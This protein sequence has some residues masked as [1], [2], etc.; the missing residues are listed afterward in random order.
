M[1]A[2]PYLRSLLEYNTWANA[3]LYAKVRELP[4]E[5]VT[6]QRKTLLQSIQSFPIRV[7]PETCCDHQ[8][9]RMPLCC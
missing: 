2:R 4:P 6:K 5:E 7:E 1:D 3:E 9:S 8:Y